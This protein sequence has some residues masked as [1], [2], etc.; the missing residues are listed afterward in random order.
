MDLITSET[1]NN[2]KCD[3]ISSHEKY[4]FVHRLPS[5]GSHRRVNQ[6]CTLH[7]A[8]DPFVKMRRDI[9]P[10]AQ[11]YSDAKMNLLAPK[12]RQ[13]LRKTNIFTGV[14]G[15]PALQCWQKWIWLQPRR[16]R[17]LLFPNSGNPFGCHQMAPEIL[18]YYKCDVQMCC[19][20]RQQSCIDSSSKRPNTTWCDINVVDVDHYTAVS[21][22]SASFS[23]PFVILNCNS[24]Q[25][26]QI[27]RENVVAARAPDTIHSQKIHLSITNCRHFN[28]FGSNSY[29]YSS[30][31]FM[32][33]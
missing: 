13:R 22:M 24:R 29:Y 20:A 4:N 6:E 3:R 25:M 7:T 31:F 19:I 30:F 32:S 11:H 18:I 16:R 2:G 8:P 33:S 26:Y 27:D 17:K 1:N 5:D 21:R 12:W 9:W 10:F 15:R 14:L 23:P 28:T